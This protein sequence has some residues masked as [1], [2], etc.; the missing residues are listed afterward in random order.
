M[1]LYQSQA[2]K[3]VGGWEVLSGYPVKKG[4]FKMSTHARCK[5]LYKSVPAV[6]AGYIQYIK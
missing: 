6:E 5:F 2:T 3:S 4:Y 1:S